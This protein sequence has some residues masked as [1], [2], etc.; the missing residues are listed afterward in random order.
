M[1]TVVLD[2]RFAEMLREE[3][4]AAG[5]D[6]WDEVWEGTY[7]MAP[8]PNNEHQ[9]IA[10]RLATIC[11]EIV[12]WARGALVM[13]GANVSDRDEGWQHN[14]R[15]PDVAVYLSGSPAKNCDTH[16]WG[17]PDFAVE[18]VS[19]DDRTRNKTPFYASVGT[20]ELLI[21]ERDPWR[22]DLLRLNDGNF[23][24]A[25]VST[26]PSGQIL[27]SEAL[28]LSFCLIGSDER[29]S[30]KVVHLASGTTWDV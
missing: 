4:A 2:R 15:C 20:R 19:D 24:S 12:G 8:L 13:Q 27:T 14:Y 30:I 6:R 25:G 29:P 17:G 18:I 23:V 26:L 22:L 1:A 11:E 21:V 28:P 5:S 7:V 16:W 9:H 3:R 10:N